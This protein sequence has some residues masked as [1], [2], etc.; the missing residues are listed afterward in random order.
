MLMRKRTGCL[1]LLVISLCFLIGNFTYHK[2]RERRYT[3]YTDMIAKQLGDTPEVHII[4]TRDCRDP[5]F[6]I[7]IHCS[8]LIMF[9]TQMNLDELRTRVESI[10]LSGNLLSPSDI[11]PSALFTQMKY[12]AHKT[13]IIT[14]SETVDA[15][16]LRYQISAKRLS[17]KDKY[18]RALT[19]DLYDTQTLAAR[20]ELDGQP[21]TGNVISVS[22]DLGRIP[23]WVQ[24]L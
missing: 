22:V 16:T 11:D 12:D 15:W 17:L 13:L 10:G 2:I 20:L 19:I 21:L 14:G 23:I 6:L 7:N 8:V 5:D 18:E 24:I 3:E 1:L 4:R 9:T